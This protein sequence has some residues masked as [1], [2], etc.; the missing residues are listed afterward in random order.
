ML[1]LFMHYRLYILTLSNAYYYIVPGLVE[2]SGE[3]HGSLLTCSF[4]NLSFDLHSFTR[5]TC[6][7]TLCC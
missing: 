1:L 2:G 6:G 7:G 4:S 5:T 3:L